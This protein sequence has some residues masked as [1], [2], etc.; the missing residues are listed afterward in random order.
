MFCQF[1]LHFC[2]LDWTTVTTLTLVGLT[3]GLEL[4]W[5]VFCCCIEL[6]PDSKLKK[7]NIRRV[8]FNFLN[9]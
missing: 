7:I 9:D 4:N 5:L 3:N 8:L 2:P 1:V 6:K